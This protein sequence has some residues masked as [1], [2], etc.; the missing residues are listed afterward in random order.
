MLKLGAREGDGMADFGLLDELR[1]AVIGAGPAG[2]AFSSVLLAHA[3]ATGRRVALTLYDGAC[4]RL[5]SPP[6][7]LGAEARRRLAALGAPLPS[8]SGSLEVQGIRVYAAGASALLDPPP[9]GLWI[10]DGPGPLAGERTVKQLLLSAAAVRGARSQPAWAESVEGTRDRAVVRAQGRADAYDLVVGA[11]GAHSPLAFGRHRP[12]PVLL[13]AH[14]RLGHGARDGILQLCFAPIPEVDLLAVVPSGSSAYVLAVGRDATVQDLVRAL[15][16]LER[17]GALPPGLSV[18][19]AERIALPAGTGRGPADPRCLAIGAAAFGGPLDAPLLPALTGAASAARAALEHGAT[20]ALRAGLA[21]AQAALALE[22]R[23][24]GRILPWARRAGPRLPAALQRCARRPE[25]APAGD[26]FL[27]G[28]PPLT[29]GRVLSAAR[30]SALWE[31]LSGALAPAPHVGVR[32]DVNR[33]LAYVIDDDP[34]QRALLADFLR[35][36]GSEVR[37]F[38]SEMGIL[39]AAARER[40]CAVLLDVV[41]PWVDGLTLC[42]AL[43]GDPATAGALLVALSGLCRKADRDA[44]IAAGADAF[45][46]K[47]VDLERLGRLLSDRSLPGGERPARATLAQVRGL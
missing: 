43:R 36:R 17:D 24:Q 44:A 6:A 11:F 27:L 18:R 31:I 20:G 42:R 26:S 8:R 30:R 39:D 35:A 33:S 15:L 25:A 46:S 41:L 3:H 7:V 19:T 28:L 1:V 40:P 37:T 14:A 13:G 5:V 10:V 23:R 29:A 12:P 9:G 4:E 32:L 47:P 34:D 21:S 2:A 22:A 16:V 38:G 45:L